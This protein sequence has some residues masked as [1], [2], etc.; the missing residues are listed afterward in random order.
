M[1]NLKEGQKAPSFKGLNEKGEEIS[2]ADYKGKKLILFF[3]PKDNTPTCTVEACNFRDNYELLENKGFVLLGV[4]P[5]SQRKH[6]NFI[7]KHEFPFSLLA[8]VDR[9]V[10]KAYDVW[11]PKQMFGKK[12][13]GVYRTTFVIDEK[14]VIE[15]I[16]TKVKAKNHTQ[17]ILEAM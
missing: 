11:G 15:K 10:I 5:D 1:T 6:Q 2:L 12:Y 14:G 4:S 9:A 13:E 7:K 3:Y 17:Q 16:F 8:D